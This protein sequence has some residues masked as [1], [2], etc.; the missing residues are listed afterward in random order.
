MPPGGPQVG[1][2]FDRVRGY[3]AVRPDDGRWAA[4]V[5]AALARRWGLD[6]LLVRG[7]F[8][9]LTIFGGFGLFLYGL[10]WLFLPQPDGR[11]HA[12]EVLRG[13]VTAGF[14]G[15]VLCIVADT[16]GGWAWGGWDGGPRP[17]GGG[18]VGLIIVGA[19]VWWFVRGRHTGGP[20]GSRPEGGPGGW[21][22]GTGSGSWTPPSGQSS[23]TPGSGQGSWTP[24][25]PGQ[26]SPADTAPDGPSG[27]P[28][29]AASGPV[30]PYGTPPTRGAPGT[31]GAPTA[32]LAQPL[33]PNWTPPVARP[34]TPPRVD[35]ARPLHPLTLTVL[36]TALLGA[37]AVLLWDRVWGMSAPAGVVAAAVA[38]GV[39][40]LGILL[41]WMLGRRSGGLAPIGILL[42]VVALV[43]SAR[44]DGNL[45]W[46]GERT[47][48]PTAVTGASAYSLAVG[49]GRLDLSQVAPAGATAADPAEIDVRVGVGDLTVVA[50]TGVGV[51]IIGTAAAGNVENET[52]LTPTAAPANT[53]AAPGTDVNRSGPRADV[54]VRSAAEPVLL[55]RADVG[56]GN[57]SIVPA[58]G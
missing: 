26:A 47:W 43:G 28:G 6:P 46:A 10:G 21:T 53:T 13:T 11:I 39:I 41:A 14:V 50:P 24:T 4:G 25:T 55:V 40:A 52:S 29:A 2:F 3:G 54:D 7:A 18:L 17:F 23:W 32:T 16:G 37:G 38:L 31:A 44:P 1:Q 20:G 48:T 56:V 33:A 19:V 5:A 22:P 30:P 49:K 35:H 45:T 34:W 57:L 58:N 12:Q 8:V 42:A 9:L 36:G 27:T 51:R 15:G